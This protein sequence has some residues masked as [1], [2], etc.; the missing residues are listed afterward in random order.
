[1]MLLHPT[2]IWVISTSP[3]IDYNCK[4]HGHAEISQYDIL[5]LY[6]VPSIFEYQRI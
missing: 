3:L 1:M 5:R 2:Y 4:I 6:I